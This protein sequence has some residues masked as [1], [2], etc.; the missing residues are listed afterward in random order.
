MLDEEEILKELKALKEVIERLENE[1][2]QQKEEIRV[3]KEGKREE[4]VQ[5]P[6][7]IP[8]KEISKR[9]IPERP[10]IKEEKL[11]SPLA[12]PI[13]PTV[14]LEES[15]GTKWL[16]RLGMV[17]L[18]F[19]IGFFL[20]YAFDNQWIGETGRIILGLIGGV[21]L[22][23]G[24]E[25]FEDKKFHTYSRIFTGG[26]LAS[27]YLSLWAASR[28]YFLVPTTPA[29]VLTC[30]ITVAAGFFAVRYNSLVVA[31]YTLI[32][33][34]LTP[35]LVGSIGSAKTSDLL[36][37]LTYYTIL[38]LGILGLAFFKK[39]R[40]LNF[41]GFICTAIAYSSLYFS[42]LQ[43]ESLSLSFS[44]LTLY[45]LIF[46]F[47]AFIY[48]IL[49][50]KPTLSEDI[51]L[52]L[53][54]TLF[55]YGFSYFL[56]KPDFGNFLGLFTFCLAIFYLILAYLAFSYN[57]N[58]KYLV[59]I[60]LGICAVLVATGLA[61]Q[62]KQ[63][64]VTI[65]WTLEALALIWIGFKLKDYPNQAYP[66]RFFGLILL[67]PPLIRL[68]AFDSCISLAEFM[69]VFNKRVFVFLVYLATLGIVA[70][71]YSGHKEEISDD[72]KN[73][74]PI[75]T[76]LSNFLIIYLMSREIW[77]YFGAKMKHGYKSDLENQRNTWL[78]I[79]WA[80]YSCLLIAIGITKK[81]KLVRVIALILFGITIFKVFF[82][83]LSYL[84][85][86][87]RIMSFIILGFLLLGA[88]FV[89]NKYKDK[90]REFI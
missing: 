57:P 84:T 20:K 60:F 25:Y 22:L 87:A 40:V 56:L 78:S 14:S 31:C 8:Y 5:P 79:A 88:G 52:T 54:N 2:R 61:L 50:K 16:P 77:D 23:F 32:G 81:Y 34:F 18:L 90:I 70:K 80:L 39:W 42:Q 46:A 71:L 82:I 37:I 68:F 17:A 48:N 83:D 38:N 67:I 4:I 62:L 44:Y 76:G 29:F 30:L 74:V 65:L 59:L 19:G 58:D 36:F 73:I 47:V 86:F 53:F 6:E 49:Y 55:F 51:Y 64:W 3:L 26:G 13:K 33:G 66:T 11:I 72:E 35:A 7:P 43:S 63:Y 1:V 85:G 12:P 28:L 89:Y 15:I 69:P 21:L 75:C 10:E 27:L 24:G 9:E 45:F 41:A